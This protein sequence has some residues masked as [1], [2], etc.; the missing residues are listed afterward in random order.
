MKT[1]LNFYNLRKFLIIFLIIRTA[2][3][4]S[5]EN[6]RLLK[7]TRINDFDE[8]F[9]TLFYSLDDWKWS[10]SLSYHMVVKN[11]AF[12]VRTCMSWENFQSERV[13]E[14]M[15][16]LCGRHKIGR[17]T[18]IILELNMSKYIFVY[19]YIFRHSND[20][21]NPTFYRDQTIFY[22]HL[23]KFLKLDQ[24]HSLFF[25]IRNVK[26]FPLRKHTLRVHSIRLKHTS[27]YIPIL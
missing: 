25:L 3:G 8:H 15:I 1:I 27:T 16:E 5:F 20:L 12:I 22:L 26:L 6:T 7:R 21:R 13:H 19:V 10:S 2:Y 23:I 24:K 18:C 17:E 14:I 9:A 4:T 11:V